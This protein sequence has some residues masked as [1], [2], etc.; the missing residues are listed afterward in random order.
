MHISSLRYLEDG[1]PGFKELHEGDNDETNRQLTGLDT[2]TA[3]DE[4]E[5]SQLALVLRDSE[6]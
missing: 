1:T 2:S 3:L 4:V 6:G 5:N